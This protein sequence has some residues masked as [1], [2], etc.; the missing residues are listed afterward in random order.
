MLEMGLDAV[1]SGIE[2]AI[3]EEDIGRAENL[4]YPAMDQFPQDPQLL[5][6]ASHLLVRREKYM[7]ARLCAEESLRLNPNPRTYGNLGAVFRR[8]NDNENAERC[9]NLAIEYEPGEK[10]AWNNLAANYVN[11]GNPYP[12]I[13]AAKKALEID[14]E[15]VKAQWNLG[16]L[17]LETGEFAEGFDNYRMGLGGSDRMLR[18][19]SEGDGTGP[20]LIESLDELVDFHAEHGRKPRV[21]VWGEQGIGDEIMFSTI[22]KDMAEYADIIFECHPR[23]IQIFQD[24]YPFVKEFYPTRK[25]D[26]V[27]W[28]FDTAPCEFKCPIG[29]LARFFRRD[30]KSFEVAAKKRSPFI[31]ADADLVQSY[32][33]VLEQLAPNK[34]YVGVAWTGG[35]LRTMRWY[36]SCE[37]DHLYQLSNNPDIVMVS[38]QYEDDTAALDKFISKTGRQ[39]LRFPAIT[40]H[41]DYQHTLALVQALDEVVTVCQSVAHLSAAAGQVT[42]VLVPD[43]PAWRYGLTGDDWYWY[44]ENAKL[45][46]REGMDWRSATSK[47]FFDMDAGPMPPHEAELLKGT[48]KPGDTML[49]LGCKQFYQYKNWFTAKGVEH[50]SVDLNGEGG[51]LAKDLQKPLELGQFDVVTNFGTTEHVNEQEPAWR[52]IHEALKKD[53]WFVSTTPLPGDWPKHGRWYPNLTFYEQFCSLNGYEIDYL[54]VVETHPERQKPHRMVCMRAKKVKDEPF[55]MPGDVHMFENTGEGIKTGAYV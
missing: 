53:G 5:F 36:R 2:Q 49:E 35:V 54:G 38:L 22:L 14:P 40:Q 45:Y 55:K 26:Y 24:S 32:R 21:I 4:L 43:K 3:G 39:I 6:Y 52:N 23:L 46:R 15:F 37:L 18:S 33:D 1:Y 29:D 50:T 47:L 16:L 11:E 25:D 31:R 12:G 30:R 28:P 7:L 13:D 44:G 8:M 9:L 34:H 48:W 19:Y 17:Q 10:N 41:Y 27:E 20:K 51:A 42:R